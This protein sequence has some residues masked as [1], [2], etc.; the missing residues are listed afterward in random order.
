MLSCLWQTYLRRLLIQ[1]FTHACGRDA[2]V[3]VA[4]LTSHCLSLHTTRVGLPLVTSHAALTGLQVGPASSGTSMMCSSC[5][6]PLT[7]AC[8]RNTRLRGIVCS[9]RPYTCCQGLKAHKALYV[10]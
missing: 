9:T 1:A 4:A 3:M 8:C 10:L 6:Q 5:V 7:W 2:N